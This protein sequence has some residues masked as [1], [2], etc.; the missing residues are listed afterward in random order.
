VRFEPVTADAFDATRER[1]QEAGADGYLIKP[2]QTPALDAVL[3]DL[4]GRPGPAPAGAPPMLSRRSLVEHVLPAP[5]APA[6]AQ[7]AQAAQAA[8]STEPLDLH[9]LGQLCGLLKVAGV[10]PL[11]ADFFA[12]SSQAYAQLQAGLARVDGN[13]MPELAHRFK[14]AAQLL[15][16]A[17]LASHA[18]AIEHHEGPWTGADA[19]DASAALTRAWTQTQTLC[20]RLELLG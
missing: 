15:S 18:E 6:A 14:G 17:L 2:F 12:D 9:A 11:F 19:R 8:A 3:L 4:F 20:R 16:C 13:N 7:A 10:R 1:M 5:A